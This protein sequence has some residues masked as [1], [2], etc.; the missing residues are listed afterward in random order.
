MPEWTPPRKNTNI[1]SEASTLVWNCACRLEC[2]LTVVW[3]PCPAWL[4]A[5]LSGWQWLF[6]PQFS[7]FIWPRTADFCLSVWLFLNKLLLHQYLQT[8]EDY[9]G[10]T[11]LPLTELLCSCSE[12]NSCKSIGRETLD[13]YVR[14][15]VKFSERLALNFQ[16]C[17]FPKNKIFF[18][19]MVNYNILIFKMVWFG[20]T[21]ISSVCVYKYVNINA[22]CMYTFPTSMFTHAN[23]YTHIYIEMGCFML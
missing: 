6:P 20:E 22:I 23:T 12:N 18:L 11:L 16:C 3:S 5:V 21:Y 1:L 7:W 4:Q 13:R 2:R 17:T 15:K 8:L 9:L 14:G 19:S 10:T